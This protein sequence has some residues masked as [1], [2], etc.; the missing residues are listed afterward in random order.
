MILVMGA[1]GRVGGALVR[2]LGGAKDGA[3]G[4]RPAGRQPGMVPFDLTD[5]GTF[6]PALKGV[7]AVFLM[8]PPQIARGAAFRPFLDACMDRGIRRMVVL[9][10]KGADANRILPHHA[11]EQ[12]VMRR[13][14]DWTM[15]RPADFMQN[16]ET[17]HRD[18]IRLH[19]RIA[20][21]AGR[22]ASAFVDVADLG[23]AAARVLT[24]PA[25]IGRGYALT[26]PEALDFAQVADV[27]TEVLGRPIRYQPPGIAGF[28][29]TRM[30]Q[31]VPLGM[32]LVMTALY[33]VQRLGKAAE[34]TDD[35]RRLLSR[36]PGDLR[37]YVARN[38]HLWDRSPQIP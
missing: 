21:P 32:A 3:P 11:M 17:V 13:P 7:T 29:R 25:H 28:V 1:S 35:L 34:V 5:P 37:A 30:G 15:L 12:E 19:D 2:A 27:M 18:D 14:F 22:G 4:V 23:V 9:S 8:R 20:V 36:P 31:G 16:L 6:D 26:G 33:T 10:V 38:A 24:D